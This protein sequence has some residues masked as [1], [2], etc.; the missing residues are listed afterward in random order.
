MRPNGHSAAISPV[1]SGH[2][3][4]SVVIRRH[5]VSPVIHGSAAVVTI[6]IRRP[7]RRKSEAAVGF[8]RPSSG[9]LKKRVRRSSSGTSPLNKASATYLM[10]EALKPQSACT[11]TGLVQSLGLGHVPDEGG[12]QRSLE[13][14]RGTQRHSEALRGSLGHVLFLFKPRCEPNAEPPHQPLELP[15]GQGTK[16]RGELCHRLTSRRSLRRRRRG[17]LRGS[18]RRGLRAHVSVPVGKK[19]APC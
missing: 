4:S 2:Q 14:L 13:A 19:E 5:Q 16:R 11:F 15:C 8:I 7:G 1:I 10:R 17:G 3:A 9:E 6:E 12:H 18:H